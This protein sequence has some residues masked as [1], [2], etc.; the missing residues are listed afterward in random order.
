MVGVLF[1]LAATRFDAL[2]P[3]SKLKQHVRKIA[4]IIQLAQSRA[5]LEGRTLSFKLETFDRR[6]LLEIYEDEL[7]EEESL[8][9]DIAPAEMESMERF[10]LGEPLY[11]N[12]W[13]EGITLEELQVISADG[14]LRDEALFSPTGWND[15]VEMVWQEEHGYRQKVEVWPLTGRLIIHEL[16][17]IQ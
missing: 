8:E 5:V 13:P 10:Q 17:A 12:F 3:S 2:I 15:G 4:D 6:I 14:E 16:E 9:L 7:E 1:A 11:E